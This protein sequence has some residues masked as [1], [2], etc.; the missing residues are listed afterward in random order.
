M[1]A[2]K[3]NLW[4]LKCV[5]CNFCARDLLVSYRFAADCWSLASIPGFGRLS[6][7]LIYLLSDHMSVGGILLI[8]DYFSRLH[9]ISTMFTLLI[10]HHLKS[11]NV[12]H[13]LCFLV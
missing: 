10:S 7:L 12:I 4:L 5:S 1:L 13:F 9:G 2:S 8:S 11:W 6:S 3:E